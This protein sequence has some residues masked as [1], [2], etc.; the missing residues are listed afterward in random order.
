MLFKRLLKYLLLLHRKPISFCFAFGLYSAISENSNTLEFLLFYIYNH[1]NWITT[2]VFLRLHV[3]L[4]LAQ[5][6]GWIL[7]YATDWG[8]LWV[9]SNCQGPRVLLSDP[10]TIFA[11]LGLGRDCQAPVTP[12]PS[13]CSL[14]WNHSPRCEWGRLEASVECGLGI[15]NNLSI[16]PHSI[17]CL[18]L[19]SS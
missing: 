1:T 15:E 11:F 4:S 18:L 5:L 12:K 10:W 8:I 14:S 17:K 2:V 19:L 13:R 6:T 9:C 3:S 16:S 7:G